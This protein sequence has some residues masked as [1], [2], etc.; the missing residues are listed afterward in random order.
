MSLDRVAML[1][2]ELPELASL[3][4]KVE[5]LMRSAKADSTLRAY[6]ADWDHFAAWARSHE[7]QALPSTPETVALYLAD[8]SASRKVST[9]SRRLIA[10]SFV[11]RSLRFPSPATAQHAVVGETVKG[12]RRT[13]GA[14]QKQKRALLTPDIQEMLAS[15]PR[16]LIGVRDRALLLI[17]YAGALRR[18]E[19]SKLD[20]EDLEFHSEGLTITVRR[21]KADQEAFGRR[22]GIPFGSHKSTCPVRALRRW[23]DAAPIRS[24]ALFRPISRHGK[25]S[26]KRLAAEGVAIVAK[27]Y[28]EEI[29]IPAVEVGGHSLRS[30]FA[31]QAAMNGATELQIMRQTGHQSL[32]MLRRYIREGTLF[33]DNAAAKLGL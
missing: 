12:I 22:I 6:K 25:V 26:S 24:G 3:E 31:T 27:R 28:A 19:L 15:L 30:G 10:I 14:A 1:P 32:P 18:S 7:L 9:I 11:H 29:G 4:A 5:Q 23:L 2:P 20:M 13:L 8:L 33:R 16:R 21:S 17:A